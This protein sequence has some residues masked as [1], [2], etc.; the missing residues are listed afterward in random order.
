MGTQPIAMMPFCRISIRKII[1]LT[2][3][4]RTYKAVIGAANWLFVATALPESQ[5][6]NG[7][8]GDPT[9]KLIVRYTCIFFN[10]LSS[11]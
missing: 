6:A 2:Q 7:S 10:S 1:L 8:A 4:Q 9:G 11:H 3:C 5:D